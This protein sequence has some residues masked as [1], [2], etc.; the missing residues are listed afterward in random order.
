MEFD[1]DGEL[2]NKEMLDHPW[3]MKDPEVMAPVLT[4]PFPPKVKERLGASSRPIPET[5]V[6]ETWPAPVLATTELIMINL[7]DDPT[8]NKVARVLLSG[9]LKLPVYMIKTLPI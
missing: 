2:F 4:L 3:F 1:T 8:I 5:V 6:S 9:G 7:P